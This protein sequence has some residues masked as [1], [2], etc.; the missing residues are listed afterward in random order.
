MIRVASTVTSTC[1][2][3]AGA[4]AGWKAGATGAVV[5]RGSMARSSARVGVIRNEERN[6]C[7]TTRCPDLAERRSPLRRSWNGT[8]TAARPADA[9]GSAP[10]NA[11]R[12]SWSGGARSALDD[13]TSRQSRPIHGFQ[14]D[15]RAAGTEHDPQSGKPN[16]IRQHSDGRR[17]LKD[18]RRRYCRLG[19]RARPAGRSRATGRLGRRRVR[20]ALSWITR[21]S[22][23]R[24]KAHTWPPRTCRQAHLRGLL[25]PRGR[26]TA[27]SCWTVN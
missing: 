8:G 24:E 26:T 22:G 14:Y 2:R 11:C 20:N 10:R 16:R 27:T 5:Y 3:S 18:D 25:R 13:P 19:R 7:R 4:F 9:S 15:H 23:Q 17:R 21:P 12:A 1:R 6:P